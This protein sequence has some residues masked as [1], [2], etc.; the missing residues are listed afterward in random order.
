MER[1]L[2]DVRVYT[3]LV[4]PALLLFLLF[5][6]FPALFSLTLSFFKWDLVGDMRFI[7]LGNYL[8]MVVDDPVFWTA[9]RNTLAFVVLSAAFQLPLAFLLANLLS[10]LGKTSYGVFRSMIFLP[11]TF[12]GVA[13]SLMFYFVLHPNAGLLNGAL[14]VVGLPSNFPWL[15]D[16]S[17]ALLAVIVSLAW[18]WTGYH[19]VIFLTGMTTVPEELL[20]AARIDGATEL[21]VTRHIILPFLMPA[22]KVSSILCITSSLKSFDQIYIMTFGGP[23]HSSEVLASHMYMNTFAQ[24]KYGYGSALSTVLFLLCI[25]SAVVLSRLFQRWDPLADKT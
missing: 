19:M 9:V 11:V 7:G 17:T 12:S 14:K 3:L 16:A 21:Q 6:P 1:M 15:G 18:Q 20:E 23:N 25:L 22:L 2:R 4:G 10:R 8:F 13:V 5:V 24:L